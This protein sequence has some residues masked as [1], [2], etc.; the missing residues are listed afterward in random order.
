M[1]EMALQIAI[2]IVQGLWAFAKDVYSFRESLNKAKGESRTRLAAYFVNIS[3]CIVDI[4]DKVEKGGKNQRI[5]RKIGDLHRS[6]AQ[7]SQEISSR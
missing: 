7:S 2:T 4:A 1:N 6:I 3:N 5:L